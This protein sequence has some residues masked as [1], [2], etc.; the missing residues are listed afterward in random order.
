MPTRAALRRIV[1]QKGEVAVDRVW[2]RQPAD[3]AAVLLSPAPLPPPIDAC[4]SNK[5]MMLGKT[6]SSIRCAMLLCTSAPMYTGVW[7]TFVT[8]LAADVGAMPWSKV[9]A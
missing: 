6:E 4:N 7:M 8:S 2:E 9:G 5:L 3:A 1:K